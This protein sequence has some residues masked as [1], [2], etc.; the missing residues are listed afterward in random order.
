MLSTKQQGGFALKRKI[1]VCTTCVTIAGLFSVPALAR[2]PLETES[3]RLPEKGHGNVQFE[4]EYATSD[5]GRDIAA[6]I[7]IEYGITDRLKFVIEPDVY[8]SIKP[9]GAKGK[10]GF[11]DTE[12][13][14][15]YLISREHGNSPAFAIGAEVKIPT[16]KKPDLGTGKLDYRLYGI[17]S[18]RAGRFDLHANLGYTVVTSPVGE[19]LPNVIDYSVAAEYEVSPKFTL[20]SEVIGNS[21]LGGKSGGPLPPGVEAEGTVITGLLGGIYHIGP[22]AEFALAATYDSGSVLLIRTGLTFRF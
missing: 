11:G 7:V 3:A 16:A 13:K 1:L 18:K 10:K 22:R 14:L 15:V 9:K 20:V 12:V 6:P 4:F 2:Q 5:E 21:P 19:R 8:A 17:A